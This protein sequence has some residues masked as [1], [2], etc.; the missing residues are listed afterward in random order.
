MNAADLQAALPLLALAALV[1]PGVAA[2]LAQPWWTERRR[3]R[4]REQ[5]FPAAWALIVQRRVP[6]ARRLPDPLRRRL[7]GQIQVFVAEK[8]FIGCQGLAIDDE[9]RITIAALACLLLIGG[10]FYTGGALIYWIRQPNPWPRTFGYH[11]VN[12]LL[13]LVGATCHYVAIWSLLT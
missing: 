6:L 11:E 13:G 8:P 5:P 7:E 12:H 2:L 9:V 4:L 1:V 10:V 3:R